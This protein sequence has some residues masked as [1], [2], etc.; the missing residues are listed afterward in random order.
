MWTVYDQ[1]QADLI[2]EA[3]AIPEQFRSQVVEASSLEELAE[4]TGM[5]ADQLKA[6]IANFNDY[7]CTDKYY[8]PEVLPE[9]AA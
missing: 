9:M 6:T 5:K 1:T 3:E 7:L 4:K 8:F 2:A